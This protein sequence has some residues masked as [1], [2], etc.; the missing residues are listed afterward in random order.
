MCKILCKFFC[1]LIRDNFKYFFIFLLLFSISAL[2]IAYYS[3]YFLSLKPCSLCI[4]QRYF[5]FAF[6]LTCLFAL[7]I[8]NFRKIFI[9]VIVLT[10]FLS[11]ALCFYHSGVERGFFE[12][13]EII[14]PTS[15]LIPKTATF[16][17][18]IVILDKT[19][20]ADCRKPAII[21]LGLSMSEWNFLVNLSIL[22][23]AIYLIL[24]HRSYKENNAKT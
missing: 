13:H 21:L 17:E 2:S 18:T 8:K 9:F 19:E 12:L 11:C 4:Y 3:Q 15:F 5:Y 23:V 7:L 24:F 16:E 1:F 10:S 20:L 6:I 14:C 22:F